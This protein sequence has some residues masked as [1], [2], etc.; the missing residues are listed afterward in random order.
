LWRFAAR[1]ILPS[2]QVRRHRRTDPRRYPQVARELIDPIAAG[3]PPGGLR[4]QP[5]R[6]LLFS[7]AYTRHAAHTACLGQTL[8]A[9]RRHDLI[10]TSSVWLNER[11]KPLKYPRDNQG[12]QFA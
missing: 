7:G 12:M 2:C 11:I 9:S 10:S 1:A 3:E 8:A 5:F 4:P 6:P